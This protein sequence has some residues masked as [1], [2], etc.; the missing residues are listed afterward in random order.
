MRSW[1]LLEKGNRVVKTE[2]RSFQ[3]EW[4]CQEKK[5]GSLNKFGI[6]NFEQKDGRC[7]YRWTGNSLTREEIVRSWVYRQSL[8]ERV[9]LLV[10][11]SRNI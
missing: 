8:N 7:R 5:T 9:K 4:S 6:L 10:I 1:V 2:N 3:L 11:C